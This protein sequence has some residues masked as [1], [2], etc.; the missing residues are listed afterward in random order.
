MFLDP[1][2]YWS[3]L[4]R[5]MQGGHLL[6]DPRFATAELRVEHGA[7]LAK[8]I[9]ALIAQRDWEDWKPIFEAWDAPWELVKTIHEV[10][11]D[12]QAAA[13]GY[14]FDV[15]VSAGNY[16]RLAG[17]PVA[18]DGATAPAAR[19]SPRLG[20]HSDEILKELGYSPEEIARLRQDSAVQ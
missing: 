13:N 12:P 15:E 17:G 10:A 5:N 16:V 2:R 7:E 8:E 20:E 6:T 14:L 4:C 3:A 18:F 1:E 19:R 11:A 9:A